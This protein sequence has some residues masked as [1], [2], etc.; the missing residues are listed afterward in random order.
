MDSVLDDAVA[1]SLTISLHSAKKDHFSDDYIIPVIAK[2]DDYSDD[3]SASHVTIPPAD[4]THDFASPELPRP[5]PAR[6]QQHVANPFLKSAPLVSV[7][8]D[9]SQAAF[10][11]NLP[12]SLD[13]IFP[14]P[15]LD[16]MGRRSF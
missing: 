7:F 12:S 6:P 16:C 5:C 15:H 11:N 1:E 10:M 4:Q 9:S 14:S 13:A 3:T 2:K 8:E